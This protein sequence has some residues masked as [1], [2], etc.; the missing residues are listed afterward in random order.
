MAAQLKAQIEASAS[1]S[2]F[3]SETLLVEYPRVREKLLDVLL[4]LHKNTSGVSRESGI[5]VMASSSNE[6]EVLL[7]AVSM[8]AERFIQRR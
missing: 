3:I 1:A 6:R 5:A 7:S 8:F 4:R 2:S